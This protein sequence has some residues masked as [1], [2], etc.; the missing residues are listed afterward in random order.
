MA[1]SGYGSYRNRKRNTITYIIIASAVIIAAALFFNPFSKKNKEATQN[2][3]PENIPPKKAEFN[4]AAQHNTAALPV[5]FNNEPQPGYEM[6]IAETNGQ[7]DNRVT[8]LL[9]DAQADIKAG[10]IVS[11]RDTLNSTLNMALTPSL[12]QSIKKQ[13]TA[14]SNEWLFS[15]IVMLG[16]NLCTT[17]KVKPGDI[18]SEIGKRYSIPYQ[19]IMKINNISNERSLRAG[20]N[21]KVVQGPFHAMVYCSNFTMD[22]YLQNIYI[23]SYHVGLGKEGKDTPIGRWKVEIGGKLIKP[24]WTDPDTGKT[25]HADDPD[26]PLGSGWIALEGI[27]P[28]TRGIDGIA[29]HGTKDEDSIGTKSS[30][31]CIRLYNGELMEVY[32]MLE[33]GKS[34]IRIVE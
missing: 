16:D 9:S 4:A 31:G 17:Y 26:Y 10:R 20:Q 1:I 18:L 34:E 7:T 19:L 3:P 23:K 6:V 32:D 8:A 28:R 22:L 24:T 13:L 30:R 27:D 21:L 11:A 15:R 33:P 25:Y 2:N 14:L 12:S 5:N 29:L